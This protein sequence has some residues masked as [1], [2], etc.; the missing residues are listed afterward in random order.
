MLPP[1]RPSPART[2][3]A[4][5]HTRPPGARRSQFSGDDDGDDDILFEFK[6]L[7]AARLVAVQDELRALL[8]TVA[9]ACNSA[10][11]PAEVRL[12]ASGWRRE[13]R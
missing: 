13:L 7:A 2:G 1:A 12:A 11:G 10:G 6:V 3:P 4:S 5:P 9:G 8:K